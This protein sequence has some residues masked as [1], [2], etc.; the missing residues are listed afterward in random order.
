MTV[1]STRLG[2]AQRIALSRP[3][4]R[5]ALTAELCTEL[6]T[7]LRAA[8]A[9]P[10]VR[11]VILTGEGGHFSVGGD[12]E[13][14]LGARAADDETLAKGLAA[15]Q[16]LTRTVV[17]LPV[18]V[19][20]AVPGSAAG[21]GFDLMVAADYRIA[22]RS[23]MLSSAFVKMGLV[24]DGG[25]TVLLRRLVGSGRAL[26]LLL[27]G[28]LTAAAQAQA[29]GLVDE[30]VDDAQLEADALQLAEQIGQQPRETVA[31]IKRLARARDR[32]A[33]RRG[34]RAEGAA[35]LAALSSEAF[36]DRAAA[37]L[38]RRSSK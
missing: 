18:P 25:S 14:L 19:I 26:R 31:S 7:A 3:E 29:I 24:P 21:F 30:V 13:W 33:L 1:T 10:E 34:L 15:F 8:A 5:N 12:L 4:K 11:A 6:T 23:A 35:Q 27:A 38:A 37:F 2:V 22:G 9:D 28:E 32:R 20:A 16:K 17:R 36:A